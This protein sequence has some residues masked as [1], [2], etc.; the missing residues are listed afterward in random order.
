MAST[1]INIAFILLILHFSFVYWGF[2]KLSCTVSCTGICLSCTKSRV[3]F[4]LFK[5][6]TGSTKICS[7]IWHNV[8]QP[9]KHIVPTF[10][11]QCF[12]Y[13]HKVCQLFVLIFLAVFQGVNLHFTPSKV[14]P[15]LLAL[16]YR[17]FL[18]ITMMRARRSRMIMAAA[19]MRY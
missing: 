12:D 17:H 10:E 18:I 4:L 8:F 2:R 5:S 9:L 11:T 16:F 1:I 14:K 7:N 19:M 3:S 13:L 6:E 15:L